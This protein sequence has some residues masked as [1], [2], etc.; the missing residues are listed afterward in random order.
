MRSFSWFSEVEGATR[1]KK[2]R[3]LVG[4]LRREA[5][6][7]TAK[8]Q[9]ARWIGRNWARVHYACRVEPT[10]LEV[11]RCLI[12][13][14]GLPADFAGFKI[15]QLSDFHGSKQVTPAYLNQAVEL[16]QAQEADLA[17][18]TGD[19]I[20]RGYRY[21]QSVAEIL[22]RLR[23]PHGV[24]AVLGNHDFSVR[25]ALGFRRYRHLHHAVDNALTDNGIRVL[26]NE[27]VLLN[28]G[29]AALHLIGLEDLWSRACNLDK[30]FAESSSAV[31]R[32]VLAHNPRTVE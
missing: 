5:P 16:A 20:H 13:I 25:N 28:R 21:V 22:G 8:Q 27:L 10:W 15:V 26:R 19:F 30:A 6:R 14:R 32:I 11:N 9:C 29:A 17:V 1:V 2:L 4:W 23:A 24:F 7:G 12:P 31:P 18:L 3:Q